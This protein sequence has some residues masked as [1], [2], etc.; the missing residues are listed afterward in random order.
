[1][2]REAIGGGL[3]CIHKLRSNYARDA[4][5]PQPVE[6]TLKAIHRTRLTSQMAATLT[7]GKDENHQNE[8]QRNQNGNRGN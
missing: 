8:D 2:I 6:R 4:L 5:T 1:M 3:G 7:E